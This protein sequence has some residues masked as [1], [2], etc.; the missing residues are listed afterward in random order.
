MH[1]MWKSTSPALWALTAKIRVETLYGLW[2]PG[3]A[4]WR[5]SQYCRNLS[6]TNDC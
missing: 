4:E 2:M 5:S 6:L 1:T 3:T